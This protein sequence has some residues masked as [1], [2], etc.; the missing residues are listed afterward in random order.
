MVV[1]YTNALLVNAQNAKSG[2]IYNIGGSGCRMQNVQL[3]NNAQRSTTLTGCSLD[4]KQKYIVVL[5]A[6]DVNQAGDGG[7]KRFV[8][9]TPPSNTFVGAAT[10]AIVHGTP[11]TALTQFRIM[12]GVAG[13]GWG[14]VYTKSEQTKIAAVIDLNQ[15]GESATNLDEAAI[16]GNVKSGA[17]AVCHLSNVALTSNAVTTFSFTNCWSLIAAKQ[18]FAIFYVED[19]NGN[20]DGS[21]S[22]HEVNGVPF[23]NSVGTSKGIPFTIATSGTFGLVSPYVSTLPLVN[24]NTVQIAYRTDTQ[25]VHTYL[26]IVD[27]N[28]HAQSVSVTSIKAGTNQKCG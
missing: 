2:A 6:E 10:G 7:I 4:I 8:V 5:Y 22:I 19:S 17:K 18:Y 25:N 11:N 23:T 16:I 3:A 9:T 20:G 24:L 12:T 15:N 26:M 13:V 21:L 1:S 27:K 14:A 28:L